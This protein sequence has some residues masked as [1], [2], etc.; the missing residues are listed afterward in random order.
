MTDK[1]IGKPVLKHRYC[2]HEYKKS[3]SKKVNQKGSKNKKKDVFNAGIEPRMV[4]IYS[5]R[6]LVCKTPQGFGKC[7]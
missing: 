5:Y 1:Y 6:N 4:N 3:E 7:N 2:E